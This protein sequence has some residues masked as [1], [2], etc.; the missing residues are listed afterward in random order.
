MLAKLMHPLHTCLRKNLSEK[1]FLNVFFTPAIVTINLLVCPNRRSLHPNFPNMA[2]SRLHVTSSSYMFYTLCSRTRRLMQNIFYVWLYK[3]AYH[4]S[5]I[6]I[7]VLNIFSSLYNHASPCNF[8]FH[9]ISLHFELCLKG[10]HRRDFHR[11]HWISL[12]IRAY[13][14]SARSTYWYVRTI[15]IAEIFI[16]VFRVW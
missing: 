5:F 16:Q 14:C 2:N 11:F 10:G 3:Y 6:F 9:S 13:K 15:C 1:M 4:I 7:S 12:S 8:A